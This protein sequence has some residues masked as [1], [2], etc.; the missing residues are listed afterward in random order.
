MAVTTPARV[1][2]VVNPSYSFPNTILE[3]RRV[4]L[5]IMSEAEALE[6]TG[7]PRPWTLNPDP[8]PDSASDRWPR[9]LT[10]TLGPT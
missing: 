10:P 3:S 9:S 5:D 6:V 1:A 2:A 4:L 8:D 7:W